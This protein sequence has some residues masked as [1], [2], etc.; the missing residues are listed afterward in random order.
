MIQPG[1]VEDFLALGH[2]LADG[3]ADAERDNAEINN[4]FHD[5]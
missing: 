2:V 3:D 1:V 4:D 5:C